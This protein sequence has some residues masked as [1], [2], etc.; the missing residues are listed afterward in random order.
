[1]PSVA[2]PDLMR[3]PGRRFNFYRSNR[4]RAPSLSFRAP[5]GEAEP[6]EEERMPFVDS[7]GA[8]IHWD[9]EGAGTP[10]LLIMGHLYSSR[11]WYPLLPALTREHRAI[12]FD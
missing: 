8:R 3:R 2:D 1:M 5:S 7:A 11:M 4:L 12:T 10:V 9:A 6:E